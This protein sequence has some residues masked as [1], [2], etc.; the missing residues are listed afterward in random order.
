[1]QKHNLLVLDNDHIILEEAFLP[2]C[3]TKGNASFK[4]TLAI[5]ETIKFANQDNSFF[6]WINLTDQLNIAIHKIIP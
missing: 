6:H 3:E 1:M 2:G 5:R 4:M